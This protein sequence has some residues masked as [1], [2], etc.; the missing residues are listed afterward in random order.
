MASVP[1]YWAHYREQ[2]AS[3]EPELNPRSRG[4]P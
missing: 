4:E 1:D 2:A 3:D